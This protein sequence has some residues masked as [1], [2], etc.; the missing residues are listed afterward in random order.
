M[1]KLKQQWETLEDK[2]YDARVHRLESQLQQLAS[3][4][5]EETNAKRIAKRLLK[6]GSEL[7]AF[8]HEK[9]LDATNN[10]AEHVAARGGDAK[11][12]RRQP[13]QKRRKSLGG[14]C[15]TAANR[16]SAEPKFA[17]HDSI[18]ADVCVVEP[19]P[20]DHADRALK[21]G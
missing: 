10:A 20:A 5:Y 12:H 11:D 6:Y 2:E 3:G 8:L 4:Q 13:K 1:L 21:D 9:D 17:G 19:E 16:K 7:T 18:D 15:I 14:S